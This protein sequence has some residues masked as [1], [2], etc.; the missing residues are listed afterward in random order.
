M[1][2]IE[3]D[4]R[5]WPML[6]SVYFFDENWNEIP[7]SAKHNQTLDMMTSIL[8]IWRMKRFH[9]PQGEQLGKEG[10]E[11]VQAITVEVTYGS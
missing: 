11:R 1:A 6:Y 4:P 9:L 8:R 2:N 3:K 7:D 5:L 10:L